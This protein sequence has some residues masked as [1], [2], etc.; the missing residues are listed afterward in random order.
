MLDPALTSGRPDGKDAAF[1][2]YLTFSELANTETD[3][4][5]LAQHAVNVL[6]AHFS[7][8]TVAYYER[9]GDVWVIRAWTPNVPAELLQVLQAGVPLS[10]MLFREAL[11]LKRE[12]FAGAAYVGGDPVPHTEQFTAGANLPIMVGEHVHGLLSI[13]LSAT[14]AWSAR[15]R[16]LVRAVARGLA[17]AVERARQVNLLEQERAAQDAFVAFTEAV[18]TDTDPRA[19]AGRAIAVLQ[20]RFTDGSIVYCAREGNL[21]KARAWS[22][23]LS[24]DFIA[25]LTTGLPSQTPLIA[26]TLTARAAH[27]MEDWNGAAEQPM[28]VRAYT[29]AAGYPVVINGTVNHLLLF[30]LKEQRRWSA[31]DQALVRAVGHSFTLAVERA[32]TA[33]VLRQQNEELTARTRALEAF[34]TLTRDLSLHSDPYLLIEQA[35]EMVLSLLPP[36]FAAFWEL[37]DGRWY[38][39]RQVGDMGN[40]DLQ[41]IID[42]G[43]PAGQTPTLDLPYRSGTPYF[44]DVYRQGTDVPVELVRHVDAVATLPVVVADEQVGLFNVALFHTR[45]WS[46]TDRAVLE[47]AVHSLGLALEGA[48]GVGALQ[49]SAEALGRT[50]AELQQANGEL[51]AFAYSVSHDL[52]SP[53]RH[54]MGFTTLLRRALGDHPDEQV[55][56]YIGILES[57]GERM[58]VLIDAL[59]NL[60]R[61]GQ[62]APNITR[63]D[64]EALVAEARTTVQ[65]AAADREVQWQVAPLPSVRADRELLLQVLINLL[66]NALKY[67]RTRDAAVVEVWAER[68]AEEVAVFVRDNGVGFDPRY[69]ERL[70]GV[71]QRLHRESEFEGT[72]VGLANVRRIIHR[73]GGRVWAESQLGHGATFAFTLPN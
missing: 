47:T 73:H 66:S 24:P 67:T 33:Q 9:E 57:A 49:R 16:A 55:A 32:E 71:F 27:F 63:V 21:W 48:R 15:D 45:S 35:Q 11:E 30:G 51:E 44:Q 29:S 52:R 34:A 64:L 10:T 70:F 17:L 18:G 61:H 3:I 62:Q 38:V 53:V 65:D 72:G 54:V 39:T 56:R 28:G 42:A 50:N 1:D 25:G 4:L 36:G 22:G 20:A 59:L 37:R 26:R 7:D 46:A 43:L 60:S 12:V 6:H 13:A 5:V 68:R 40:D 2:A 23:N 58:N 41:A 19:L 31:Q 14:I 8:A 69:Q